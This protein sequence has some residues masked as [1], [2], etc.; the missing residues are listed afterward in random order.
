MNTDKALVCGIKKRS[1]KA[2]DEFCHS[3]GGLIHSI[4]RY[5]LAGLCD[6][7]EECIN[8]ILLAVWRNIDRFDP[9]KNTLK[10]WVAAISKY[11]CI[12]YKRRYLNGIRP[13]NVDDADIPVYDV[14]DS[15]KEDVDS[16]LSALPKEDAEIFYR[17]YIIGQSTEEISVIT[18][19][20]KSVIYNRISRGRKRL[21][22]V[23]SE[24]NEK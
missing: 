11:R 2:F 14:Y 9:E 19:I 3:Y 7:Q 13:E 6:L 4:V 22:Q 21:K 10:N 23:R 8:D 20:K 18:G 1:N 17:R 24:K 16:L 12:D 15:L 5:H